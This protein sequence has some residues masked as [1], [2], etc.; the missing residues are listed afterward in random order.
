M[1]I[2]FTFSEDVENARL[3]VKKFLG[4]VVSKRLAEMRG[5]GDRGQWRNT[6]DELRQAARE[7]GVWLPHMP[8]EY[9]G[10][11]LGPSS[12]ARR[13]ATRTARCSPRSRASSG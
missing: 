13:S 7:W 4:D 1:A 12:I 3:Q 5:S 2:D 6:I 11:G 8:E 9:G 10:M